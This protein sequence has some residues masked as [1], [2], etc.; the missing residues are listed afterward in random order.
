MGTAADL[1]EIVQ[2]L[3]L[4]IPVS[5]RT[6]F[7]VRHAG[8]P[9]SVTS[10]KTGKADRS[11]DWQYAIPCFASYLFVLGL[12]VPVEFY[13]GM[14]V[15]EA[16]RKFAAISFGVTGL[17]ALTVWF[18]RQPTSPQRYSTWVGCVSAILIL[19][20]ASLPCLMVPTAIRFHRDNLRREQMAEFAANHPQA[21]L[22]MARI[23]EPEFKIEN[24]KAQFQVEKSAVD[25]GHSRY[26]ANGAVYDFIDKRLIAIRRDE[27][28]DE[29]AYQRIV[30]EFTEALGVPRIG[31]Q[32][33]QSKGTTTVLFWPCEVAD[34]GFRIETLDLPSG[35]RLYRTEVDRLS[36]TKAL[37]LRLKFA[38]S[39]TRQE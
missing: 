4:A 29:S 11:A 21:K 37:E 6:Y 14:H 35:T 30:S 23:R 8:E 24:P 19:G 9:T 13:L 7:L 12:S 32:Q 18:F 17:I 27:P 20:A 2:I 26:S 16:S 31:E 33:L 38:E 39:A 1:I 28:Y 22:L 10:S 34:L 3:A 25:L 36:E 5:T 15:A